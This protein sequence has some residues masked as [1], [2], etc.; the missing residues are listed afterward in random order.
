MQISNPLSGIKKLAGQTIWYGMSSI[1]GRFLNYLLT[2]LLT[3]IFFADD[4]GVISLLFGYAAF[5]NIIFTYGMETSYFRFASIEPEKKVY[6]TASS[7]LWI[8]TILFSILLFGFREPLA[9]FI[10]ISHHPEY[11]TW[12]ILIVALDT[13]AVMP[14]AK[15]RYEQ[16]PRKYAFIKILNI[17]INI[18]LILFFLV[19]CKNEYE[20]NP[21]STWAKLYDP[22]IGLGY[23]FI[24]NL[25]ASGITI[26]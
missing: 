5:L 26:L 15:L 4:Y 3:T 19:F 7:S 24:A 18:G 2:P 25:A 14:F 23:V 13:L 12:T 22:G 16:R 10:D 11:I 8:S 1:F 20:N 17:L 9:S 6:N 21:G